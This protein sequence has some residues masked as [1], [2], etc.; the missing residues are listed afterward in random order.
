VRADGMADDALERARTVLSRQ[1]IQQG[2]TVS[3]QA[4]AL[5]FYE[6]I[7]TYE[8]AATYL[9]RIGRVTPSD[10]KRVATK[11]LSTA[12]HAQVAI[13]PAPR[14]PDRTPRPGDDVITAWERT[15]VEVAG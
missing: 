13:E 10:I 8:F 3:G 14:P 1:Y 7:S 12:E 2:E 4:G 6:M 11:Y 5:G 15:Q 9:D